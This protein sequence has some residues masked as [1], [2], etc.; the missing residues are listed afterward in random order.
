M[1]INILKHKGIRNNEAGIFLHDNCTTNNE[2]KLNFYE[3]IENFYYWSI[4]YRIGISINLNG[5][6]AAE[7]A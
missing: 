2:L 7:D 4:T 5:P 1:I 6:S 3:N